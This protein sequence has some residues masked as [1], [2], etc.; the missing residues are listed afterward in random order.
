V[1]IFSGRANP[2]WAISD[3]KAAEVVSLWSALPATSAREIAA[4]LGYRGCVLLEG[5]RRW[6]AFDGV[7]VMWSGTS[8]ET[9]NDSARAFE[10]AILATAPAGTIPESV[11]I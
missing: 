10:R 7:A 2:E 6:H 8:S 1:L 3:A 5:P 4:S 9:R 11:R